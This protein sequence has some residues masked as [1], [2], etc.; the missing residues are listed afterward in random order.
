MNR[1][2][3]CH[4]SL[5]NMFHRFS[6]GRLINK[7]KK[8]KAVIVLKEKSEFEVATIYNLKCPVFNN[9]KYGIYKR[10]SMLYTQ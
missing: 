7:Y 1:E 6:P 10:E 3:S 8:K 4:T 2:I 9:K 5:G